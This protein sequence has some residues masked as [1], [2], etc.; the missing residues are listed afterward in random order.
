MFFCKVN[1]RIRMIVEYMRN[2]LFFGVEVG[3]IVGI[4]NLI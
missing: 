3:W 4:E 1:K 2:L